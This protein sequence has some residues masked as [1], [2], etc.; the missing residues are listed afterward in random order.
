MKLLARNLL[1]NQVNKIL[2]GDRRKWGLSVNHSDPCWVEWA[3]EY[4]NFYDQ[5]QRKGIGT[6]INDAGYNVMNEVDLSNKTVLEIGA[7]DIRHISYWKGVP[8]EYILA[9]ISAD[10]LSKAEHRLRENNINS[11]SYL[12]ERS[13]SLPIEDCSVDVIITFYSL[14]H[15][16]PLLPYIQ[17]MKRVLKP[18]GI[19]IGA[20]PAEGGL[21]WGV[22]RAL[23][24]RRWFKKYTTIDPDKIICWEHPNFADYVLTL[25]DIELEK[26][27][28]SY[29]P[30]RLP[31][32]DPNLIIKFVYEKAEK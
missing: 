19:I 28:H 5:N 24:S 22:G 20:I 21:A 23:T 17:E 13:Q 29:W 11:K 2:W 16:Y 3:R 30:F 9:D 31:L 32:I 10:M 8:S 12:L 18:G 6:K 4:S 26:K 7:G 25:M 27:Q 14:E 1:P 15:L